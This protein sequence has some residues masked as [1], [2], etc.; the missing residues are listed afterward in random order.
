MRTYC[1]IQGT[2]SALW[3]PEWEGSPKARGYMYIYA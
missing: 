3:L 2:L 1:I